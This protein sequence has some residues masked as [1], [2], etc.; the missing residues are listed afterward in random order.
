MRRLLA[1]V[2][3]WCA[4]ALSGAATRAAATGLLGPK[5]TVHSSHAG[6]IQNA[7]TTRHLCAVWLLSSSRGGA[8]VGGAGWRRAGKRNRRAERQK[9]SGPDSET[10]VCPAVRDG[11]DSG[12]RSAG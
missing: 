2:W 4:A 9:V 11:V 10:S 3:C 5:V 8:A 12:E 7:A 1:A 6:S